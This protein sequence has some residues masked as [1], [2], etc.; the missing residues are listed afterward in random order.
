M[1][2][3]LQYELKL[4]RIIYFKTSF[5]CIYTAANVVKGL[6]GEGSGC[7]AWFSI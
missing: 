4:L 7:V 5:I 1:K 6:R 3:L 2:K